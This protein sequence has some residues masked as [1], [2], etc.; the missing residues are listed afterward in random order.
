MWEVQLRGLFLY[1]SVGQMS[2]ITMAVCTL[3]ESEVKC[4]GFLIEFDLH[5]IIYTEPAKDKLLMVDV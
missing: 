3:D 4:V 1:Y 5:Q 2:P